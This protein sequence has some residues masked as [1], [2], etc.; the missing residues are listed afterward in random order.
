MNRLAP[1]A[2]AVPLAIALAT[3][4]CGPSSADERATNDFPAHACGPTIAKGCY[5]PFADFE[6]LANAGSPL[7][8]FPNFGWTVDKDPT[9]VQVPISSAFETIN[10]PRDNG[11]VSTHDYRVICPS[12]YHG[13]GSAWFVDFAQAQSEGYDLSGYTHF[14]LWA[15]S[16][17]GLATVKVGFA[18]M[19]TLDK[20]SLI[21]NSRT[22]EYPSDIL[23]D[24]TDT[25]VGA[26][27][28]Y[29]DYSMKIYL[30]QNWRRYDLALRTL[31]TGGWGYPHEF[32]LRHV[33]R[34]KFSMLPDVTYDVEMDDLSFWIK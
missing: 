2:A 13:W 34:L 24:P 9:P 30:T 31:T 18:D 32:D 16:N 23:C 21:P 19:Y 5:V 7:P 28:C 29:D 22:G 10:S 15:K 6:N 14:S 4:S 11:A 12:S 3:T 27:G 25:R 33:Y 17:K 8:P 26:L 1:F 20:G